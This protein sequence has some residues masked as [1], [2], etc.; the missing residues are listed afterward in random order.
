[1]KTKLENKKYKKN[2]KIYI[3]KLGGSGRWTNYQ[4]ALSD[5]E[6]DLLTFAQVQ[7][8]VVRGNDAPR[9]GKSGEHFLVKKFFTTNSMTKR[10]A[11]RVK[12]RNEQLSAVLESEKVNSFGTMSDIGSIKIDGACYSNFYG[13]GWNTIEICKCDESKFANAKYLSRREVYNS[14]QPI[15]IMKFRLPKTISISKSDCDDSLGVIKVE[16]VLGFV[17]WERKAKIFVKA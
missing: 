10:L 5:C 1:M 12:A 13:D 16:N 4:R 14:K 9:G 2:D 15:T 17:I 8:Y 3:Y 6:Q 7:G 11:E